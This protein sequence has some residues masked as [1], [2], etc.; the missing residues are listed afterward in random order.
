[1]LISATQTVSLPSAFTSVCRTVL[2]GV[3]KAVF[4]QGYPPD[5]ASNNALVHGFP[6][7]A[8]T[9]RNCNG[10]PGMGV[11]AT[12]SGGE[13]VSRFSVILPAYGIATQHIERASRA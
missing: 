2:C 5:D 8:L 13:R 1:M 3:A 10:K 7:P 4:P 12:V 9:R 6:S 11:E